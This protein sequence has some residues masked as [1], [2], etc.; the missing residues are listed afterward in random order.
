ML[1][2]VAVVMLG[3]VAAHRVDLAIVGPIAAWIVHE[4]AVVSAKV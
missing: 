2:A 4:L 1:A 3:A